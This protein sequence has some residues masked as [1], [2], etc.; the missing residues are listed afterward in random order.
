MET[1][2]TASWE[3]TRTLGRA[4]EVKR[5]YLGATDKGADAGH[6]GHARGAQ[7]AQR[8]QAER[9]LRGAAAA[10]RRLRGGDGHHSVHA[11]ALCGIKERGGAQRQGGSALVHGGRPTATAYSSMPML[12]GPQT[13]VHPRR[14][15]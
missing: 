5:K 1:L 10:V 4:W 13:G 7:Q 11:F 3:F 12:L 15:H 8:Y 9:L 2:G 14:T 6:W